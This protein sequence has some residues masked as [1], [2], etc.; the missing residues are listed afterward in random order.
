M[1][2]LSNNQW[3]IILGAGLYT[4]CPWWASVSIHQVKCNIPTL[5][6]YREKIYT[7]FLNDAE[8]L[9]TYG[10][11]LWCSQIVSIRPY[12]LNSI[13]AVDFV[14]ECSDVAVF[15]WLRAC[16]GHNT[17]VLFLALTRVGFSVLLWM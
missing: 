7:T 14:T 5:R 12:S 6:P 10:C 9:T 11:V 15:V 16:A 17:S 3:P 8:F 4:T 13:T 2:K 1:T